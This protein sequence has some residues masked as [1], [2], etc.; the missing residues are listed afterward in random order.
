[1][2]FPLTASTWTHTTCAV[3][4]EIGKIRSPSYV[5]SIHTTLM[6]AGARLVDED[7]R[8]YSLNTG[9]FLSVGDKLFTT[10]SYLVSYT[11]YHCSK[12]SAYHTQGKKS[13][14]YLNT[15]VVICR[16]LQQTTQNT[17]R[18]TQR[19]INTYRSYLRGISFISLYAYT[20]LGASNVQAVGALQLHPA[21][22]VRV[23]QLVRHR[24]IHH[25]LGYALVAAEHHLSAGRPARR[26]SVGRQ[27]WFVVRHGVSTAVVRP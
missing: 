19:A 1:M 7:G 9:F 16:I 18:N 26:S 15:A 24:V 11:S 20:Y 25:C 5:S 3:W 10:N 6:C 17:P 27:V 2:C 14:S 4:T 23:D 21:L 22:V 8:Q 12:Q 13:R